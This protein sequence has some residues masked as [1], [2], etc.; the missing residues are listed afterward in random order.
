[1]ISNSPVLSSNLLCFKGQRDLHENWGFREKRWESVNNNIPG[2]K[3]DAENWKII[4]KNIF[5]L[6]KIFL[7]NVKKCFYKKIM[8]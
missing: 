8:L 2:E 5:H 3:T 7:H 1:M 6:R 4:F